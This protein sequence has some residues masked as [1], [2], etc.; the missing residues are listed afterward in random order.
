M[1]RKL[2]LLSLAVVYSCEEVVDINLPEAPPR[3]TVE[4]SIN[5]LNGTPGNE[6][7]IILSTTGGFFDTEQNFVSQADIRIEN[8]E[9][10]QYIFA[11]GERKG[12]YECIDFKPELNAT[13]QLTILVNGETYRAKETLLPVSPID[14][15]EQED[16]TGFSGEDTEIR[17]YYTDPPSIDNYYFF[18]Y[19]SQA[20]EAKIDLDVYDDEFT[21]GNQSFAL[22]IESDLEPGDEIRIRSHGISRRFFDYLGL[23]LSQ[24]GNDEESNGGPFGTAPAEVIG[25]IVN[26]DP[27]KTSPLGYFRLSQV[28]EIIYIVK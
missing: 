28:D 17:M 4:A 7:C 8:Q 21:Q 1:L 16:E 19:R 14:F 26:I 10:T 12:I 22:L 25:N 23:L 2:M 20:L 5:W 13:Y 3:L 27:S 11:E 18:E 24:E 9:G 15:I 6:Q